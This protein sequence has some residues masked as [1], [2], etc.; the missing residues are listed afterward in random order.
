MLSNALHLFV[1]EKTYA[2]ALSAVAMGETYD[3]TRGHIIASFQS[4]TPDEIGDELADAYR[5]ALRRGVQR[6]DIDGSWHAQC[7]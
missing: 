7:A 6:E 2:R 1:L 5:D 3:D 4:L